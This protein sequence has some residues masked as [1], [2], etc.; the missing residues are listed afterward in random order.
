MARI[1]KVKEVIRENYDD[2]QCGL[3]FTRNIVGDKMDT[4]YEEDGV[5]V[6]ICYHWAYFEVFGLNEMEKY[7]LDKFYKSL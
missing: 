4:V 6:D 7:E 2:A 1:D 3:F 5:T